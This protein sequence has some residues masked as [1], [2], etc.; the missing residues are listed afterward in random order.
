MKPLSFL[1]RILWDYVNHK[2]MLTQY[3]RTLYRKGIPTFP[4]N[5]RTIVTLSAMTICASCS[6]ARWQSRTTDL[7]I[8]N[9]VL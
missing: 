9:D 7:I 3:L 2:H 8:T 1:S 4:H 5:I 6:L